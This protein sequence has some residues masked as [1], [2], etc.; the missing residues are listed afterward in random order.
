MINRDI[1]NSVNLATIFLIIN[2]ILFTISKKLVSL[3]YQPSSDVELFFLVLA[4]TYFL[5]KIYVRALS[6]LMMPFICE[7]QAK[8]GDGELRGFLNHILTN[9]LLL[10]LVLAIILFLFTP[11]IIKFA[12]T[13]QLVGDIKFASKL[14]R[15]SL[16]LLFIQGI[17]FIFSQ[18]LYSKGIFA[19][20]LI[21]EIFSGLIF[22]IYILIAGTTNYNIKNLM[23]LN[24]ILSSLQVLVLMPI[25][26]Y[27]GYSL[28]LNKIKG[29]E[30]IKQFYLF[31]IPVLITV[32]ASS[33]N[34]F[35]DSF[36]LKGLNESY[37]QAFD[38]SKQVGNILTSFLDIFIFAISIIAF[39]IFCRTLN[40]E[41]D[42]IIGKNAILKSL[43]MITVII[44]PM[45]VMLSVLSD[46][47]MNFYFYVGEGN[48]NPSSILIE[49]SSSI[50]L[51]SSI[52]FIGLYFKRILQFVFFA[53]KDVKVPLL[54]ELYGLLI[55]I[56]LALILVKKYEV[57][58]IVLANTISSI[59]IS[60]FLFIRM[61]LKI[62]SIKISKY[63]KSL[64]KIFVVSLLM[65]IILNLVH[66]IGAFI[67]KD[68]IVYETILVAISIIIGMIVYIEMGISLNITDV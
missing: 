40:S 64:F 26:K 53:K 14:L 21:L 54:S 44:F 32:L 30:Y 36:L 7:I 20:T 43:N 3:N 15:L 48:I 45:I 19:P 10:S 57:Y 49:Q 27:Q 61:R 39:P 68:N 47:I 34:K 5:P 65:G 11:T 13:K 29:N 24:L 33:F 58:S 62:G 31:L 46:S 51:M 2:S 37:V 52:G 41:D 1:N 42:V 6:F 12:D 63:L 67:V 23:A 35:L 28:K 9:T 17:I 60:L 56:L 25:C 38:Y 16:P 8:E 50:L 59:I 18:F 55:K 4:I 22:L 66:I